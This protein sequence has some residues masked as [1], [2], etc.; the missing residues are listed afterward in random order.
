M[1]DQ[2]LSELTELAA[3]PAVDDE[4]YIRDISEAAA[5]ESK[6]ITVANLMAGGATLTV[7]ETEVFSGNSPTS[8]TDLD[9]HGTIGAQATLVMI[10]FIG[11][12]S[13]FP[14]AFRKKG[15]T[16]ESY[17]A[18]AASGVSSIEL[19]NM[20]ACYVLVAT[21]NSGVIQWT[22]KTAAACTLDVVAY[23]K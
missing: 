21:D 13:C 20:I 12:S 22:S 2:K 3:T 8:W 23:I 4:L 9:L 6:R 10:K 16:D 11:D 1:A 18:G 15:D 5:A 19:A 7:A 14:V 17:I